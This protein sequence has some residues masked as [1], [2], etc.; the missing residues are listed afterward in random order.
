MQHSIFCLSTGWFTTNPG[1]LERY[2]YEFAQLAKTHNHLEVCA[3]DTPNNHD[4]Q[5]QL[6]HLSS[7]HHPL[8]KRLWDTYQCLRTRSL[9]KFNAINLHFALYSLPLIPLRPKHTPITF[10]FHGP[11][12]RESTQEGASPIAIKAQHW[13][14]QQVY[15]R[16]DRFITLSQA[17]ADILHQDYHIPDHKIHIIPGG[18]NTQAF[19]IT[20]SRLQARQQLGFPL[21]RPILFAP[22]RLVQRMGL[23]QLL[24]ALALIK[25]K[26]PN[27][28]LAIA[29]KGPQ[30]EALEIQ[31]EQ[32]NLADQVQFLGYVSDADLTVAYQA[33]DLTI[34][35]SQALEGFGLIVLES[36]A[37]GTPVITTPIGGMPEILQP[38]APQL[39]TTGINHEAIADRIIQLL[40]DQTQL[41]SREA[42]RDYSCDHF[43]W[44]IIA[45][46]VEAV[47]LQPR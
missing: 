39:I 13:I 5:L 33:A 18:I 1:G 21:D 16:C 24:D 31:A 44:S 9:A 32:L 42:C 28:W 6:T 19:Q 47:L 29:G 14:E 45:P 30:R 38:F 17:F 37:C 15:N 35:P 27:I 4:R 34:V 25:Q 22:R 23:S 7:R 46:Q 12:A 2:V 20:H 41:P 36:L 26:I 10:T 11:W 43:D 3:L 40:N 8:P